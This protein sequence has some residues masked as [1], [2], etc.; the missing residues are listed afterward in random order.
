MIYIDLNGC[1]P[2]REWIQKA[3][4]LKKD[5]LKKQTKKERDKFIKDNDSLWT[6]LKDWLLE[7]TYHKCWYSE[8]RESVSYYEIDHFRPKTK[9]WWLSFDWTNYRIIGNMCNRKKWAKFPLKKGSPIANDPGCC[10]D[11]EKVCLLDPRNPNDPELLTFD[12]T[13]YSSP[14]LPEGVWEFDRAS[15][16][17]ETINLNLYTLVDN[18]KTLWVTC[19][20]HIIIAQNLL[21]ALS[22]IPDHDSELYKLIEKEYE[23]IIIDLTDMI[24]PR[25]Q[26]SS[27]ARTCLLSSGYEWA[28]RIAMKGDSE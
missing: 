18:R 13:G 23:G 15:T 7:K 14:S 17:I 20:R 16:T 3:K 10:L 12:E 21:I 28:K 22:K 2:Q 5:L 19:N 1:Q 6:D 24:H 9:Y 8:A 11:D 4:N 26:F 27:T 25:S